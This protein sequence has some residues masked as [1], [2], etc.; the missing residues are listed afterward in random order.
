MLKSLI[1]SGPINLGKWGTTIASLM[2]VTTMLVAGNA[3]ADVVVLHGAVGSMIPDGSEGDYTDLGTILSNH[4]DLFN[5][6]EGNFWLNIHGNAPATSWDDLYIYLPRFHIT[7]VENPS[8]LGWT[9]TSKWW[10]GGNGST[11]E[12]FRWGWESGNF[13]RFEEDGEEIYRIEQ[14]GSEDESAGSDCLVVWIDSEHKETSDSVRTYTFYY[15]DEV[16]GSYS[17]SWGYLPPDTNATPEPATLVL[18]GL[19]L[20]GVGV[21]ARRRMKK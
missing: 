20:A 10:D 4:A 3:K 13:G 18:M 21:V 1:N 9:V 7:G 6:G 8:L 17:F 19:G 2:L 14:G 12:W 11:E 15:G 16:F 5:D